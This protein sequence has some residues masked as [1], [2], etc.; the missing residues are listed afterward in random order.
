MVQWIGHITVQKGGRKL[1]E[2]A[3]RWLGGCI[4][5]IL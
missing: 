4:V 1:P 3:L 5:Q 2:I